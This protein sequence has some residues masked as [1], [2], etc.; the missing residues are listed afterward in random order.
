[1]PFWLS[2]AVTAVAYVLRRQLQEPE[3][4][5][6]LQEHHE[7]AKA[8]VVEL[9]RDHWRTVVRI[10]ACAT[11]A[12]VN[13]IVNVFALAYATQ[14][15]GVDRADDARGDRRRQRGRGRHP[16]AASACSPTASAASRCSSPGACR[17]RC[18]G[19]RVLLRRSA[20]GTLP[21]ICASAMRAHRLVLRGARTASTSSCFPEQFPARVRYSGMAIG[22]M[23]GLLAAGFT[24]ALAQVARARA[25]LRTGCR[26]PGCAQASSG[27]PRSPR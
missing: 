15:A 18:D 9:F 10:A 24:P 22:L 4:F 6:E 1:M 25:S 21:W 8:P 5:H 7:T 12:M 16:A 11:F 20:P 19:L 23:V 26:W 17:R 13:T 27:S 3:V 14:V 2:L